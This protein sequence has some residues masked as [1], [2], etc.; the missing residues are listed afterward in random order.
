MSLK[1]RIER[2]EQ[3]AQDEDSRPFTLQEIQHVLAVI[4]EIREERGTLPASERRAALQTHI[5]LG[6][7]PKN[8]NKLV[9]RAMRFVRAKKDREN[10][11]SSGQ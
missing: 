9:M 11:V 3:H 10:R 1:R 4:R 6:P 5:P 7:R 8:I 2:L